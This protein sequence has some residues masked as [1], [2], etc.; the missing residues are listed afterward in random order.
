MAGG[1]AWRVP[2]ERC[3]QESRGRGK[4]AGQGGNPVPSFAIVRGYV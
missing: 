3:H 4:F 1:C 2:S